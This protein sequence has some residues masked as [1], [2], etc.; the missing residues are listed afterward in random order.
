MDLI[1]D[2]EIMLS[3]RLEQMLRDHVHVG[4][5]KPL[6]FLPLNTIENVLGMTTREYQML[7][8]RAGNDSILLDE[9][10]CCIKSGAIYAFNE[11]YLDE[12][13][14]ESV[15]L[16]TKLHLP[17]RSRDFIEKIASEWFDESHA[18]LPVIR[19]AFGDVQ[20]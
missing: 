11:K 19:K 9:N 10:S 3:Q 6:S 2:Q 15:E 16:L 4:A 20:T 8:S 17:I 5:Q 13:L 14:K 12:V 7:V 1:G 18:I